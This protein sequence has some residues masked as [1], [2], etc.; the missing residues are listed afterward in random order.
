MGGESP[1][2]QLSLESMMKN[3][4]KFAQH[5]WPTW[6]KRRGWIAEFPAEATST[7]GGAAAAAGDSSDDGARVVQLDKDKW[8]FQRKRKNY[9]NSSS[10]TPT[11]SPTVNSSISGRLEQV[12]LTKNRE[13]LTLEIRI[14]TNLD[15]EI[16]ILTLVVD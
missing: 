15:I 2:M 7:A 12:F 10:D 4:E 16:R 14:W 13:I 11:P 1:E 5:Q 3:F 6:A 9:A 8:A